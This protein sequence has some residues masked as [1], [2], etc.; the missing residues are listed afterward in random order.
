MTQRQVLRQLAEAGQLQLQDFDA[1]G[2]TRLLR[3]ELITVAGQTVTLTD[4]GRRL[5]APKKQPRRA[6]KP[7]HPLRPPRRSYPIGRHEQPSK[8][9]YYAAEERSRRSIR[10]WTKRHPPLIDWSTPD[11]ERD[12]RLR[13]LARLLSE[14]RRHDDGTEW[15]ADDHFRDRLRSH[16]EEPKETLLPEEPAPDGESPWHGHGYKL[17]DDTFEFPL[18]MTSRQFCNLHARLHAEQDWPHRHRRLHVDEEAWLARE[19]RIPLP[20]LRAVN[21]KGHMFDLTRLPIDER[22]RQVNSW[23]SPARGSATSIP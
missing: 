10:A 8:R 1:A 17:E 7:P 13:K 21:A 23:D 9:G 6:S 15:T 12:E 18:D 20:Q 14:P 3:K 4:K 2:L 16:L 19:L 11:P 22:K 5:A